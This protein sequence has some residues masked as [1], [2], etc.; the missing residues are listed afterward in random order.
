MDTHIGYGTAIVWEDPTAGANDIK[1]IAANNNAF[2]PVFNCVGTAGHIVPDCAFSHTGPLDIEIVSY[3]PAMG[4]IAE[5]YVNWN[6]MIPGGGLAGA[7]GIVPLCMACPIFPVFVD[8]NAVGGAIPNSLHI[9]APDHYMTRNWAYVY[10]IGNDIFC[11][12]MNPNTPPW[13][14]IPPPSFGG[15]AA[16][17]C[18]TNGFYAPPIYP[19]VMPTINNT[20]VPAVANSVPVIAFDNMATVVPDPTGGPIPA[21]QFSFYVAWHTTFNDPAYNPMSNAY[22]GIQVNEDGLIRNPMPLPFNW[23]GISAV[24]PAISPT[25]SIALSKCNDQPQMLYACFTEANAAGNYIEHRWTPWNIGSMKPGH[26]PVAEKHDITINPNPFK[27][28]L[29]IEYPHDLET[30]NVQISVTDMTGRDMGSYNSAM[31]SAN[32]FLGGV[33][34]KLIPGNYNVSVECAKVKFQKTFKVTR[35]D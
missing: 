24:P 23:M 8:A 4:N 29:S 33:A 18:F 6:G 20:S 28:N 7:C 31:Y 17:V 3:D 16:T 5:Y 30:E 12:I 2:G 22:I 35:V 13:F 15:A 27:N 34:K 25:P 32:D 19:G 21:N 1:V 14:A 9:D 26:M 11:R 10:E